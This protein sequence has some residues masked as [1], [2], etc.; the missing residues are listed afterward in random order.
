MGSEPQQRLLLLLLLLLLLPPK[1]GKAA[2]RSAVWLA[3]ESMQQ[4]AQLRQLPPRHRC[5]LLA[6]AP[7]RRSRCR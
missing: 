5:Q 3:Q 7:D 2:A 1:G 4:S 6:R